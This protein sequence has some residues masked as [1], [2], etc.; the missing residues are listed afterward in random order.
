MAKTIDLTPTW[1]G[2]L[3]A[4][5]AVIQDGNSEGK[6]QAEIELRRLAQVADK[7]V[8]QFPNGFDAW[9]ETHFEIVSYLN[10]TVDQDGTF[11]N[12]TMHTQGTG[13]LYTVAESLTNEFERQHKGREWDGDFFDTLE[14]WLQSQEEGPTVNYKGIDYTPAQ[15]KAMR[16]WAKDCQWAEDQ[17]SD[18]IDELD[19]LQ[20]LKGVAQHYGG[21]LAQFVIDCEPV[22]VTA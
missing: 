1:A 4:L 2:I 14:A 7:F 16:E 17:G 11:A 10:R 22:K 3:P 21:G 8:E 18:F 19:D 15:I 13:G 5:L 6:R 20:I 9:H 12:S